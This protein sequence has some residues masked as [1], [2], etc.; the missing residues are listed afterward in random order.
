MNKILIL[1]ITSGIFFS[2]SK[3]ELYTASDFTD[4]LFTGGIEGPM[5]FSN[6][7]IYAV[8]FQKEGTIGL[9]QPDGKCEL[10]L[11]LPA[12]ST[13]NGIR[14]DSKGN[15]LIADYTG[16]NVL[17]ADMKTK[18]V[19]LYAHD[20]TMNQPNDLAIMKND[21]VFCSDPNWK[22][23][24]GKLWRVNTDG[25]T[26]LLMDSIGTSNGIEVSPD[27]NFLYVNESVQRIVWRYDLNE[28]G[29]ILNKKLFIRFEDGGLDG[30]KCD[31]V[32]NL[33]IARYDKGSVVKIS[34]DGFLLKEIKL[35]G[36]KPTNLTFGG[37]DGK[38][39]FVTMQDRGLFEKFEVE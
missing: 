26:T 21:I 30:M 38:T 32:G 15:M 1:L 28:K 9:V 19:S 8:N 12:G 27:D 2:C 33:Y 35:K 18:E 17:K 29:D 31:S 22:N 5:Y 36:Q 7:N 24:T 16:H 13:G 10:F 4:S 14:F 37:K 23:G 3:K 25:S 11:E 39:I 20:S 6:G 34:P